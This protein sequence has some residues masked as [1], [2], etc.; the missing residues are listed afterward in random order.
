[1][2]PQVLKRVCLGSIAKPA[3]SVNVECARELKVLRYE[4]VLFFLVTVHDLR[5]FR[6]YLDFDFFA[7]LRVVERKLYCLDSLPQLLVAPVVVHVGTL[8][9]VHLVGLLLFNQFYIVVIVFLKQMLLH[10]IFN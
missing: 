7:A 6:V 9:L 2:S 8:F 10:E 1:M 3:D 5:A 4:I